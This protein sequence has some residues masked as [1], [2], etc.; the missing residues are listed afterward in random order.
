MWIEISF[1]PQNI[2]SM[3]LLHRGIFQLIKKEYLQVVEAA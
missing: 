3:F 2:M 1:F